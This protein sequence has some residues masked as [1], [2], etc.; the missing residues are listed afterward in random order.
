MLDAVLN[1]TLQS[2]AERR[3]GRPS[4]VEAVAQRLGC[5]TRPRSKCRNAPAEVLEHQRGYQTA[6]AAAIYG[7]ESSQTANGDPV[8]PFKT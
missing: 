5:Q 4:Q 2:T 7:E 1:G 8:F 3:Y 6:H